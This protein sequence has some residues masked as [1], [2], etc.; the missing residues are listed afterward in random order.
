MLSGRPSIPIEEELDVTQRNTPWSLTFG[1]IFQDNGSVRFRVW[2][3]F[4]KEMEVN[5]LDG[6]GGSRYVPMIRKE[7]GC[8]EADVEGVSAG[9]LYLYRLDG[10]EE[11][12]DPCS[13]CQ[14]EGVHGPS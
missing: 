4:V 1:A 9:I 7:R 11:R 5:L 8:F 6:R 14:P 3:P 2:A 13:R 12:P 10:G